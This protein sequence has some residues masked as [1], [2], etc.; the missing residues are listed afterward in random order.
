ML[1]SVIALQ[2][3]YKYYLQGLPGACT[4][5]GRTSISFSCNPLSGKTEY[6]AIMPISVN[7]VCKLLT[8]CTSRTYA[9]S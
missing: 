7:Q 4:L 1:L 9:C 8:C 3:M 5:P 2:A 6:K